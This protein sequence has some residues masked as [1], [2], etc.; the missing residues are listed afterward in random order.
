MNGSEQAAYQELNDRLK[1]FSKMYEIVRFVDPLKK[2][3]LSLADDTVTKME[4][5]CFGIWEQ[6]KICDNCISMRAYNENETMIKVEYSPEKVYMVTA[7]PVDLN[8]RKIIIE[9]LKDATHSMFLGDADR[10]SNL[11]MRT[12][13][14]NLNHVALK[15]GLTGLFNRRYIT[16]R[17]PVDM[18][19]SSLNGRDLSILF[20]DIDHFKKVNDTYG[21]QAGDQVLV[22]FAAC[23]G[24]CI[25]TKDDWIARY[26]G[27]EIVVCL[28]DTNLEQAGKIAE[29]MRKEL[30][31]TVTAYI[32]KEIR[33]TASFGAASTGVDKI[34]DPEELIRLADS[35]LYEAKESGRNR[36]VI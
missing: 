24:S 32:G 20:A 22:G 4:D 2:E 21:H 35:K 23:L 7:V 3:V 19:Q 13:I 30:E 29:R 15:D 27:E 34:A 10:K 25:R 6:S 16:E 1:L 33:V 14:D 28:P 9:L 36:V 8:G 31:N 12:A 5:Q 11:E 26:G 18:I 17:L